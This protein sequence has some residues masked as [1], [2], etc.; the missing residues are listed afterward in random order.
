MLHGCRL[1]IAFYGSNLKFGSNFDRN[2]LDWFLTVR[3]VAK[4]R[5]QLREKRF[6]TGFQS[7]A[8]LTCSV[9][10]F[11]VWTNG[12]A[13]GKVAIYRHHDM[14]LMMSSFTRIFSLVLC[15]PQPPLPFP[16]LGWWGWIKRKQDRVRERKRKIE[17]R[18]KKEEREPHPLVIVWF[19]F[20]LHWHQLLLL[21]QT[22]L[23]THIACS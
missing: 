14:E 1:M 2:A 6:K 17:E 7:P 11:V 12:D 15:C 5:V 20:F 19:F 8:R 13:H 22:I 10:G 3:F 16:T 4:M 9:G 18:K 21:R 23:F